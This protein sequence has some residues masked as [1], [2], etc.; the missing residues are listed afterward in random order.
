MRHVPRAFCILQPNPVRGSWDTLLR[1]CSSLS[2]AVDTLARAHG[3]V[4]SVCQL[5]EVRP[6]GCFHTQMITGYHLQSL[7]CP[8][9]ND[10]LNENTV[11]VE[12]K[13]DPP[14]DDAAANTNNTAVSGKGLLMA[15]LKYYISLDTN[16]NEAL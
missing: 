6:V 5:M 1:S 3:V 11:T 14:A 8:F 16:I 13:V 7:L 9:Q 10:V 2:A 12:I 15:C 4:T